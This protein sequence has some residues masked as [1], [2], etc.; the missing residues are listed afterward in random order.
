M[1]TL[2]PHFSRLSRA[3]RLGLGLVVLL[4]L[5]WRVLPARSD[6]FVDPAFTALWT[7]S[8]QPVAGH[9]ATRTWLWGPAP[10]A[11]KRES[12]AEGSG[13]VRLVQYFDKGRMEIN[14]PNADPTAPGFVTGG[15]LS[16]ELISGRLQ[17]GNTRFESRTPAQ[18]PLASDRNDPAAPTY[19]SFAA[20]SS[21][22]AD[23][24][25][26][27][28]AV[29]NAV[30]QAIARDGSVA[31]FAA[32]AGYGVTYAAY[33]PLTH[34]NIAAVFWQFLNSSGPVQT[35][36]GLTDALLFNPRYALTGLPIS[37]AYWAQVKVAGTQRDVLIQAFQ[38]RVLTYSPANPTGFQ[39]EMGN[40]GLHY[41]EWRY[42]PG[43]AP[44]V[45]P[46]PPGP[47]A[48]AAL[49]SVA[50]TAINPGRSGLDLN[51][52]TVSLINND[53]SPV[54]LGGWR[55]VSP[56]NDHLDTYNFP[57]GFVLPGGATLTVYAGQGLDSATK[58]YM[59]RIT[60]LFD[61]TGFDGVF[62]YDGLGREVS[63]FFLQ[64]G[65]A[66][67]PLPAPLAPTATP[68][69][70]ATATPSDATAT[71]LPDGN[72]T[73]TATAAAG[74][75]TATVTATPAGITSTPTATPAG[76]TATITA[77]PGKATITATPTAT[78]PTRNGTATPTATVRP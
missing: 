29:G 2:I 76:G 47:P 3:G 14:N 37:E 1:K 48:P 12:Y 5:A 6:P 75:G 46:A 4:G 40:I 78:I 28:T 52:Q 61:S 7:R 60:W 17:T 77:T 21:L 36:E 33:E 64:G 66:P 11:A 49:V 45:V 10:G 38:R 26:A 54:P 39:V 69:D 71:P 8:D 67:T 22:I 58:L 57:P 31:P 43:A 56:K 42:T 30:D 51:E 13:G 41:L 73:V 68:A 62:L 72:P 55:L 27:A 19:A 9:Q 59:R 24:H 65:V 32:A 20:V 34:H 63:R 74:D 70:A 50:V 25:Q 35:A 53:S 18:I 44:T 23:E 16:V 15:L